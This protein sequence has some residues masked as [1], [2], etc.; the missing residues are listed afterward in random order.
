MAL[1][2]WAFI[3]LRMGWEAT[4]G[5]I[6]IC[7]DVWILL[8]FPCGNRSEMLA[9]KK[10]ANSPIFVVYG[11]ARKYKTVVDKAIT[12]TVSAN[13]VIR[14][15]DYIQ[16]KYQDLKKVANYSATPGITNAAF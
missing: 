15:P 4:V 11:I 2:A 5:D 6:S 13:L 10:Q 16:R 7:V 1:Q 9:L 8:W 3:V 14:L 12:G